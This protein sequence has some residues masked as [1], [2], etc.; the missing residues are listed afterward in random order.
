MHI[1]GSLR[2]R[3]SLRENLECDNQCIIRLIK[4]EREAGRTYIRKSTQMCYMDWLVTNYCPGRSMNVSQLLWSR[5]IIIASSWQLF[6][7]IIDV[8]VSEA[9]IYFI[10]DVLTLN[11]E[12]VTTYACL[13][14]LK[15]Q[16]PTSQAERI[17]QLLGPPGITKCQTSVVGSV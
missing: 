1:K 5:A 13:L 14:V 16:V 2:D 7:Y 15:Y 17:A 8:L 11:Y 9:I 12:K 6:S 10:M 4:V 3:G